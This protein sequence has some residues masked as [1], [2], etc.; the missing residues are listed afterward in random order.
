MKKQVT[1]TTKKLTD[2]QAKALNK[3]VDAGYTVKVVI[4]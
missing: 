4:K 2:K 1:V 3:L